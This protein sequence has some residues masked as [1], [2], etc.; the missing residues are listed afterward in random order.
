MVVGCSNAELPLSLGRHE[1]LVVHALFRDEAALQLAREAVRSRGVYG[2]VSADQS[3]LERLPYADNLINLVVVDGYQELAS[4]GLSLDEATERARELLFKDMGYATV[5]NQRQE[6]V[7]Y[8]EVV[9]C[10]GKTADQITAIVS[11]MYER[12]S[13]I[14]ATRADEE[15]YRRVRELGDKLVEIILLVRLKRYP[16]SQRAFDPQARKLN[17]F[18]LYA[19]CNVFCGLQADSQ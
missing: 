10:A 13:D 12:G 14:L 8:P 1:G 18:G 11:Y 3:S 17:Q 5:D 15:I 9:Y 2:R 6:R 4:G 16:G 7:G 19:R